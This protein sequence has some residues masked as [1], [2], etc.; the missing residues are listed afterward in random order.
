[1]VW[2]GLVFFCG[3]GRPSRL[4][5][6]SAFTSSRIASFDPA[7]SPP[8]AAQHPKCPIDTG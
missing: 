4:A 2:R 7:L 6:G 1:M 3:L 5:A 8:R